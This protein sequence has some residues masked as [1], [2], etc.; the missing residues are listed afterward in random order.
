MLRICMN[1]FLLLEQVQKRNALWANIDFFSQTSTIKYEKTPKRESKRFTPSNQDRRWGR[2]AALA[3]FGSARAKEQVREAMPVALPMRARKLKINKWSNLRTCF[4]N[5]N[6]MCLWITRDLMKMQILFYWVRAGTWES[7]FLTSLLTD[8]DSTGPGTT[9]G[10]PW[11]FEYQGLGPLASNNWL[12]CPTTANVWVLS[13]KRGRID[14]T[15]AFPASENKEAWGA[16]QGHSAHE[17]MTST[18]NRDWGR[19]WG[20]AVS[21]A[22][23]LL[24]AASTE[25]GF[26]LPASARWNRG[27][28]RD[29]LNGNCK[30]IGVLTSTFSISIFYFSKAIWSS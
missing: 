18:W 12:C 21:S 2:K 15:S 30:C 10:A 4:S 24:S 17:K 14:A 5:L 11:Y 7:A 22:I 3:H 29:K 13:S 23:P 8:T 16:S 1:P 19:Q 20:R 27:S 6:L 9:L 28:Q 25:F 26:T